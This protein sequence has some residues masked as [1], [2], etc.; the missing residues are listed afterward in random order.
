MYTID[1]RSRVQPAPA[2]HGNEPL[3]L[4]G[5]YGTANG[6]NVQPGTSCDVALSSSSGAVRFRVAEQHE[7]YQRFGRLQLG[8]GN[9]K[10]QECV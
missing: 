1:G 5:S 9:P 6:A 10:V 4:E 8:V 3:R 2:N 7:P